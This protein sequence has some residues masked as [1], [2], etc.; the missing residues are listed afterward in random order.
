MTDKQTGRTNKQ[1][2]QTDRLT[3]GQI[4]CHDEWQS[5]KRTEDSGTEDRDGIQSD[6][7]EGRQCTNLL[8]A[9]V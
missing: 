7:T 3:E 8:S 4:D 2:G 1:D 9:L 5:D 6:Q